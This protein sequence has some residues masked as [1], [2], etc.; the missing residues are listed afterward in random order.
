[1]K[2]IFKNLRKLWF[3]SVFVCLAVFFA[4]APVNQAQACCSCQQEIDTVSND[5]WFDKPRGTVDRIQRHVESEFT[6]HRLWFVHIL[7]ED[8]LLPAMMLMAEQLSAVAMQQTQ[9]VGSFLDASHQMET[10]QTLRTLNARAH[11][12]YHPSIGMC[13]F[14]TAVKSLAASERKGEL[15]T[16]AMSQR[17]QDRALKHSYTSSATGDALDKA[18]RLQQFKEKFCDP[19]DNNNGMQFIC[20]DSTRLDANRNQ[21]TGAAKN[22]RM[23]K[24]IDYARTFEWPWTLAVDFSDSTVTNHE[25]EILALASNLYGHKVFSNIPST[26]LEDIANDQEDITFMQMQYQNARAI[27]AKRSVAENSFSAI[28]AMKAEGTG[29]SREYLIEVLK[30]LGLDADEAEKLLA[31]DGD[32]DPSYY[33]Q[34]EI[35][36]KKALQNPDF[37][38]NLYDTPTNVTRKGVAIQAIGLMQKFDL[39]K[40]YLRNEAA[41]SVLLELAVQELQDDIE[42]DINIT[43]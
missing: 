1:M 12:D 4:L 39:F 26:A 14:G 33:A 22:E 25:E 30:E 6:A 20:A 11:K 7:W 41:L 42:N 9:I 19:A 29:G 37:Y 10:Q 36:T 13:E 5:E 27:L 28:T 21:I 17:I 40:S 38:T 15:D 43:K 34:M 32:L 18:T 16:F 2:T 23:N 8:N 3:V 35:L 31:N 24:D